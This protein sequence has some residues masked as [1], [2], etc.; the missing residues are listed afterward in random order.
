MRGE[1]AIYRCIHLTYFLTVLLKQVPEDLLSILNDSNLFANGADV[2]TKDILKRYG[3]LI[4]RPAPGRTPQ[5]TS[6]PP[7]SKEGRVPTTPVFH[8]VDTDPSQNVAMQKESSVRHV[9]MPQSG[10]VGQQPSQ[11]GPPQYP[12]NA[13]NPNSNPNQHQRGHGRGN[14]GS[15]QEGDSSQNAVQ[16]GHGG[17]SGPN[18]PNHHGVIHHPQNPSDPPRQPQWGGRQNHQ[19]QN[20]QGRQQQGTMGITGLI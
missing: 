9:G 19:G 14:S 4:N 20:H 13:Q 10:Q 18:G 6:S 7:R 2:T 5:T 15:S 8:R 11:P 12:M 3:D 1:V 16:N 17:Q